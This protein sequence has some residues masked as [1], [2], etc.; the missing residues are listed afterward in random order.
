MK[1]SNMDI[2]EAIK[3]AGVTHWQVADELGKSKDTFSV[4]LR[5]PL[6]GKRRME[7]L[8]AIELAKKEYGEDAE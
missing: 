6:E 2:R 4:W 7:I 8:K 5:K 3:N 1:T